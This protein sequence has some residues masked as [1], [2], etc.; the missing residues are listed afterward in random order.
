MRLMPAQPETERLILALLTQEVLEVP[1][2]VDR[3]DAGVGRLQLEFLE[4][5]TCRVM[6]IT[7]RLVVAWAPSFARH[8]DGIPGLLQQVRIDRQALWKDT[9]MIDCFLQL[10]GIAAGKDR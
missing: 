2:I 6:R 1:H 5:G 9:V 3:R 8:A 7:G 4:L 10:P